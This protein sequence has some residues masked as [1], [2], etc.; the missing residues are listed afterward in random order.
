MKNLDVS[1]IGFVKISGLICPVKG[2]Y[3]SLRHRECCFLLQQVVALTT[4]REFRH[5][6]SENVWREAV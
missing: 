4:A 6:I 1:S 5:I 3:S 2:F